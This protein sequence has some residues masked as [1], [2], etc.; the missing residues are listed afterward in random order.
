[1]QRLEARIAVSVSEL[2]RS[3][4]S[5]MNTAAGDPVAVLNHNK[6]LAYMIPAEVY[7]AMIE[8][9][10]DMELIEIIKSRSDQIPVGVTLDEL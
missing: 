4:T 1:M 9:L 5:I 10:D 2:K 7:E 3:P 6:V 8:R